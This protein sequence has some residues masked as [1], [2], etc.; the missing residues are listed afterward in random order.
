[1][2]RKRSRNPFSSPSHYR[3]ERTADSSGPAGQAAVVEPPCTVFLGRRSVRAKAAPCFRVSVVQS[4]FLLLLERRHGAPAARSDGRCRR[5]G[6]SIFF[7]L[8]QTSIRAL[9]TR[10]PGQVA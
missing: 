9:N 10:V 6:E 1:L 4:S 7:A 2:G 8:R 3:R 5:F